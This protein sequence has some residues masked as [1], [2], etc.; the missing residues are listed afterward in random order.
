MGAPSSSLSSSASASLVDPRS[1]HEPESSS[2]KTSWDFVIHEDTPEQEMTNLLQHSTCV[3]DISS[4]EETESRRQRER[5]EGKENVPPVDDVS[6]TSRTRFA[7]MAAADADDMMIEKERRPLGEM[8]VREYY[9]EGF[10][11]S[12]VVIVPG[13]DDEEPP[14]ENQQQQQQPSNNEPEIAPEMTSAPAI[15]L[16][17]PVLVTEADKTVEELMQKPDEP[18]PCAALLEPMEGTGECFEVWESGSAKDEAETAVVA[19]S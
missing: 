16:P 7:R 3:L 6:Q 12:S 5:A 19:C 18:A 1:L 17:E 13:D 10:D 4:D 2:S 15:A 8:D 14:S 11:E 9:T